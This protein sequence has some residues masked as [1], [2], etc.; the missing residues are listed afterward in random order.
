MFSCLIHLAK[1]GIVLKLHCKY[2]L[3]F[4]YSQMFCVKSTQ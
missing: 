1:K 4:Y 3:I 2:S